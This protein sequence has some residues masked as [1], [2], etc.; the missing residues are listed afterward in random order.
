MISSAPC[1]ARGTLITS[2]TNFCAIYHGLSPHNALPRTCGGPCIGFRTCPLPYLGR[3]SNPLAVARA[4]NRPLRFFSRARASTSR[5]ST[6]CLGM[7]YRRQVRIFLRRAMAHAFERGG[8]PPPTATYPRSKSQR[9]SLCHDI[10]PR[11]IR[12]LTYE[13]VFQ[14]CIQPEDARPRSRCARSG[15]A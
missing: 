9:R 12:P 13:L 3:K 15:T 1:A 14:G 11:L 10:D 4:T 2:S 5:Q 7:Y 6:A 8:Y